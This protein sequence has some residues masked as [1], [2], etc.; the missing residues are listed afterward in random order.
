M[1]VKVKLMHTT[2]HATKETVKQ[3]LF[4]EQSINYSSLTKTRAITLGF[5]LNRASMMC[6]IIDIKVVDLV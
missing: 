3:F 6:L 2:T 5:E 1:L 4:I